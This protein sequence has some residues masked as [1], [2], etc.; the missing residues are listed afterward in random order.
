MDLNQERPGESAEGVCAS[1]SLPRLPLHARPGA[2][3]P[4][5][6]MWRLLIE[7]QARVSAH[8]YSDGQFCMELVSAKATRVP[9]ARQL[10]VFQQLLSTA[11]QKA[12]SFERGLSVSSVTGMLKGVLSSVG[13]GCVPSR[14]PLLL[15]VGARAA[16]GAVSI[17]GAQVEERRSP[18]VVRWI[19]RLQGPDAWLEHRLTPRETEVARLLVEGLN[20][21]QI[22]ARCS[23][24]VRT[25]A[26]HLAS[27]YRKLRVSGRLELLCKLSLEYERGNVIWRPRR[28]ASV[29]R[30]GGR[31]AQR[32]ENGVSPSLA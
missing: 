21:A 2:T 29:P 9:S 1:T 5:A 10:L 14:V 20:H 30:R 23:I 8:Y 11:S 22:A 26:N 4:L 7:G 27:S 17:C 28:I 31:A 19:Y 6:S 32:Q 12:V 24:A 25:V 16:L 18:A 3:D 15:I 13:V